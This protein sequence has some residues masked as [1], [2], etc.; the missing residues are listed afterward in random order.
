MTNRRKPKRDG[1]PQGPTNQRSA[2]K[3]L[4]KKKGK[5]YM[6]KLA[7]RGG[8]ATREKYGPD[9]YREIGRKGVESRKRIYEAGKAA[10]K[11]Q[12]D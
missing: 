6:G 3:A 8:D 5:G 11:A 10:I 2:G 12:N 1:E 9:F 7:K 4:A